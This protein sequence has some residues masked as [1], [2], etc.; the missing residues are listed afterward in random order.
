MLTVVWSVEKFLFHQLTFGYHDFFFLSFTLENSKYTHK[1]DMH[2][3]I[4]KSTRSSPETHN[5]VNWLYPHIK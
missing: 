4:A 1:K 3:C 2:I 5:I